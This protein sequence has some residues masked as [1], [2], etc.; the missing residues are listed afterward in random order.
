MYLERL[1]NVDKIVR[2][3][4]VV[5]LLLLSWLVFGDLAKRK[6]MEREAAAKGEKLDDNAQGVD[7][8]SKLQRIKIPPMIHYHEAGIFCSAWL[9]IMVSF[10]TGVLAGILGIGGG[11]IRMPALVYLIGCPTHIAVGTDLFEVAISGLYGAATYTMKGRTELVAAL[12]M[13][14]GAAIG[15]Q[16]GAV[17]TKYIRGYGIRAAFGCAV[18]GCLCSVVLKLIQ[19]YFPAYASIING[20][21][22]VVVLGFVFVIS[23]YIAVRMF[24]GVKNEL[25]EKK[26]AAQN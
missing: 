21:A 11:L 5:L 14:I 7:W 9:P 18:V 8:A 22:T 20:I 25:A 3:L 6:R 16:I 13:L 12:I 10:A 17:A 2:W 4:Y 23:T 1:G 19:P 26:R 15:A 24:A